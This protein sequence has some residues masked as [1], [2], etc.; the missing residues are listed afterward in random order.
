M[1]DGDADLLRAQEEG[2]RPVGI[3]IGIGIGGLPGAPMSMDR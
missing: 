1:M 2:T 3:E